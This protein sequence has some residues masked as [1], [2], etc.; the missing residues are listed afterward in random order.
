MLVSLLESRPRGFL[1]SCLKLNN[2]LSAVADGDV[3]LPN[4]TVTMSLQP[5]LAASRINQ[6]L[7]LLTQLLK[8]NLD[9]QLV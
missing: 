7:P 5:T 8:L 4:T 6:D 3:L 2:C 9:S 1:W